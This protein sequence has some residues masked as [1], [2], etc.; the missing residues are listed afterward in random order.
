MNTGR[1][2][3]YF[4]QGWMVCAVL[5]A[6][7]QGGCKCG[8]DEA[9]PVEKAAPTAPAEPSLP[10][11]VDASLFEEL[12]SAAKGCKEIEGQARY[13]CNGGEKNAIVLAFNRGDRKRIDALP[14]FGHALSSEDPKLK[15]LAASVLYAAFRT[16]LG[17]EAKEGALSKETAHELFTVAL[18]LPD[19]LGAHTIPAA[20]HAMM[21]TGQHD[22]FFQELEQSASIQVKTMAY[23]NVMVYG[24]LKAFEKVQALSRDPG[25]AIVL[26]A[27]ESP[28]NMQNWSEEERALICPWAEPFLKDAR[29]AVAGNAASV[30][31]HCTGK[32]LD[33][34]LNH[35]DKLLKEHQFSFVHA[36]ALRSLC[37]T[38][39]KGASEVASKAQCDR[40]RKLEETACLDEKLQPR[41]RAMTLS[42]LAYVWPDKKTFELAKKLSTTPTAEVA[43]SAAQIVT[44]L[45]PQ[46]ETSKK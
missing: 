41:V 22:R 15:T 23:R 13:N 26:A 6:L 14:T 38:R 21:L 8:S 12:Q 31:S 46:L 28:R 24:R 30:L 36:S 29:P 18:Q 45:T 40:V 17:P 5:A 43:A 2:K 27:V 9:K 20:T 16:S 42:A 3:L 44:R 19:A 37:K 32:H 10:P 4:G 25:T 7:S 34:L 33:A 11:G 35:V 39:D 1:T